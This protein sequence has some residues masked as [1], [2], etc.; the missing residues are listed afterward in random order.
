MPV[1]LMLHYNGSL[2]SWTVVSLTTAKF[3]PLIFSMADY[4]LSYTA[5]LFI[6]MI[7]QDFFYTH[8][9]RT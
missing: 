4:A 8:D 1:L 6:L 5:N 9:F 3:K 2:V 7:L